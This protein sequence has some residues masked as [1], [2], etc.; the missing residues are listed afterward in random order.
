MINDISELSKFESVLQGGMPLHFLKM[1]NDK[2][3]AIA[4]PTEMGLPFLYTFDTPEMMRIQGRVKASASPK[5]SQEKLQQP[6]H[7]Q[8]ESDLTMTWT[9]KVQGR[10]SFITPHDHQQYVS[11]YSKIAHMHIP[12]NGKIDLDIKKM[13]VKAEFERGSIQKPTVLFHHGTIP[14]VSRLDILKF[15][16]PGS[17]PSTRI[18]EQHTRK[19]FE[20]EF[21]RKETG[22]VVRVKIDHEKPFVDLPKVKDLLSKDGFTAALV[23]LTNVVAMQKSDIIVTSIP[24]ESTSQK[25]VVSLT[26]RGDRKDSESVLDDRLDQQSKNQLD[27]WQSASPQQRQN[28]ILQ[29]ITRGIKNSKAE[30][31]DVSVEF[32]GAEKIKYTMVGAYARSPVDP[33]SRV[34]V[35][36]RQQFDR[37]TEE[38]YVV[39][40]DVENV[41]VNANEPNLEYSMQNKPEIKSEIQIAFGSNPDRS[42]IVHTK[43]AFTRSHEREQYLRDQPMYKQCRSEMRE[44][45]NQLQACANATMASNLLDR[46]D[47]K[48]LYRN[49]PSKMETIM[50]DLF[51]AVK[52]RYYPSIVYAY[53]QG[54]ASENELSLQAKFDPDLRSVNVSIA[55][56]NQQV[57]LESIVLNQWVRPAVVL[58]PVIDVRER[59][60]AKVFGVH[61]YRRKFIVFIYFRVFWKQL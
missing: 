36:Y 56:E 23:G 7:V 16:V 58:H 20:K 19:A 18:I 59:V 10:I 22:L 9:S 33:V 17:N 54:L 53:Q 32:Q 50:R 35:L 21:G 41:V 25:C 48:V 14:L 28:D 3:M 42:S 1:S 6:E 52:Y 39:A 4:F 24:Q 61:T 55:T 8:L 15:E 5:I 38:P 40:M 12:I 46:I 34:R 47:A 31:I 29:K 49:I 51:Y 30:A 45:N 37:H 60:M 57:K 2:E 11:E 13:E 44:G 27:L 26:Y 43:L